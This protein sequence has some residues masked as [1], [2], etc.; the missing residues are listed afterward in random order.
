ML[1]PHGGG[2]QDAQTQ[3][4]WA[5]TLPATQHGWRSRRNRRLRVRRQWPG[6]GDAFESV[7]GFKVN[8]DSEFAI[9]GTAGL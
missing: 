5:A 7:T 8:I 6:F 2:D 4:Y 9:G 3:I 1:Q